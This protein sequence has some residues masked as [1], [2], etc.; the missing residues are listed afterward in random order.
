MFF[1]SRRH[2]TITVMLIFMNRVLDSCASSWYHD[3]KLYSIFQNN[4]KESTEQNKCS[5]QNTL[6][7]SQFSQLTKNLLSLSD[8]WKKIM[9]LASRLLWKQCYIILH[10]WK[11]LIGLHQ[12]LYWR[13]ANNSIKIIFVIIFSHCST[14]SHH[15]IRPWP[16]LNGNF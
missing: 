5:P 8:L 7:L 9:G 4:L 6:F 13:C 2:P 10:Y 16:W 14:E 3:Y 11:S 1:W 12:Q 15:L